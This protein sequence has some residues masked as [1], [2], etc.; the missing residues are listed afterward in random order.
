MDGTTVDGHPNGYCS[1]IIGTPE[2]AEALVKLKSMQ[3]GNRCHTLD[4]HDYQ[5]KLDLCANIK[6]ND[7][8]EA[9]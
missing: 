3:E 4:R 2:Y 7:L 6:V 1:Q 9:V 5:S 8:K